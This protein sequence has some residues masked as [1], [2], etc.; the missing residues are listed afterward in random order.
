MIK[1]M[2][3]AEIKDIDGVHG[4]LFD[5][6]FDEEHKDCVRICMD[7]AYRTIKY[8]DLFSFMFTLGTKEQ[9][10]KMIPVQEEKGI[11]YMKTI[12]IQTTKDLKKGEFI[13]VNARIHVPT[14]IEEQIREEIVAKSSQISPYNEPIKE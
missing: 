8:T 3:Q 11:E 10:A 13:T 2:A 9:Q 6:N 5:V 7:G 1:N 4:V 12:T 14:I